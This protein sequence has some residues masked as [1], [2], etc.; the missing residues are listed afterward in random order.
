MSIHFL[1]VVIL[2]IANRVLSYFNVL[3]I[4][5]TNLLT[6]GMRDWITEL[7]KYF[8]HTGHVHMCTRAY[9]PPPHTH[10]VCPMPSPDGRWQLCHELSSWDGLHHWLLWP[11]QGHRDL[12]Q[13]HLLPLTRDHLPM[14]HG[15]DWA[16]ARGQSVET[17]ESYQGGFVLVGGEACTW[18]CAHSQKVVGLCTCKTAMENWRAQALSP[19]PTTN[20]GFY[21]ALF[22][23]PKRRRRKGLV[24]AIRTCA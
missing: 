2:L 4:P 16:E 17:C 11:T 21:L 24:S 7:L 20:V 1:I 13:I 22:P 14:W 5:G 18:N 8:M 12:L 23:G 6:G 19:I 9:P 15:T 10:T 3:I